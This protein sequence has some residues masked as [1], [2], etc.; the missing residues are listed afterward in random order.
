MTCF[1]YA[2]NY[3]IQ[4]AFLIIFFICSDL[5][6][7]LRSVGTVVV[8]T[9]SC[10]CILKIIFTKKFFFEKVKAVIFCCFNVFP[11]PPPKKFQFQTKIRPVLRDYLSVSYDY[12]KDTQSIQPS[13]KLL[14]ELFIFVGK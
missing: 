5:L 12:A 13:S 6:N 8:K 14:C 4:E 1:G 10:Y 11:V 2:A 3:N 9:E 7:C